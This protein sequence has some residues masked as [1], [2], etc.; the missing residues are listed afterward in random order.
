MCS[1]ASAVAKEVQKKMQADDLLGSQRADTAKGKLIS[2]TKP[3]KAGEGPSHT[4]KPVT[5]KPR[6]WAPLEQPPN[7]DNMGLIKHLLGGRSIF[8]G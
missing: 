8:R 2:G 5:L 4:E 3:P 1:R 7:A 6:A